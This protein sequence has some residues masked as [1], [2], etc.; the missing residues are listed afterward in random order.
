MI[1]DTDVLIWY[2]RGNEKAQ[3]SLQRLGAFA[4]SAITHMELVQGMR[5]KSELLAYRQTLRLWKTEI[6]HVD[7]SISAKAVFFVEQYYLSHALQVAGAL[8]GATALARCSAIL[9]AHD[10]H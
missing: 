4:I 5:N 1:V 8:I 9:T 3:R 10:K 7:A 6:L 2:M